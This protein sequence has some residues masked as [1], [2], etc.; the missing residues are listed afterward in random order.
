METPFG[1]GWGEV[2]FSVGVGP[3]V[4]AHCLFSQ[5]FLQFAMGLV[6]QRCRVAETLL[7]C[8][9]RVHQL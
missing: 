6:V 8:G 7:H 3:L 1:V 2:G 5:S 9:V 4:A